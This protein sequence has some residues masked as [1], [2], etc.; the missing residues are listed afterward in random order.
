MGLKLLNYTWPWSLWYVYGAPCFQ[1]L[2]YYNVILCQSN[3]QLGV[4]SGISIY[5]IMFMIM[6]QYCM[7][8][9][10]SPVEQEQTVG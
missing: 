2:Y 3:K 10:I 6:S 8:L 4:R 7:C 1:C 9:S 5:F